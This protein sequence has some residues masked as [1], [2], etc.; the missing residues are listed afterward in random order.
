MKRAS[1][2]LKEAL[3]P[4][5]LKS[6]KFKNNNQSMYIW[7]KILTKRERLQIN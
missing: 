7:R 2:S 3:S 5:L 4:D 1:N 6:L